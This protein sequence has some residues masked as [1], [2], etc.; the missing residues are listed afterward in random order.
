MAEIAKVVDRDII[1]RRRHINMPKPI[2]K[3]LA[4]A[5]DYIWWPTI[6][7]DEVEREFLDQKIDHT[8]KTFA[9][10]G[11]TPDE[12]E[13]QA[14]QYVRHFRSVSVPSGIFGLLVR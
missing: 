6:S 10:L 4:R 5:F 2:L 12:L 3:I 1:A 11:I 14:Y 9:D 7:P 8:A 13:A